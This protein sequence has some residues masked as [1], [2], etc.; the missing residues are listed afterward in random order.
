[1]DRLKR[2]ID[3]ILNEDLFRAYHEERGGHTICRHVG[4]N[5]E[6]LK[7][8]IRHLP[9]VKDQLIVVS[10]FIGSTSDVILHIHDC[11]ENNRDTITQWLGSEC[12]L[13]LTYSFPQP[14]GDAIVKGTDWNILHTM[15]DI[16]VVI[17]PSK[18][19]D[20]LF[21]IKTTY[22]VFNLDETDTAWDAV[23]EYSK[24]KPDLF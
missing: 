17:A 21:R 11:L 9:Y 13:E 6:E 7:A 23:D 18:C 3:D 15:S 22:P 16:W 4:I 2:E 1:M 5:R 20:R 24:R 14:I 8:R 19:K 10:R 12:V